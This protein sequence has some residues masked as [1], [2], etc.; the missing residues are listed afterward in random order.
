MSKCKLYLATKHTSNYI[1]EFK[2]RAAA[3]DFYTNHT[4]YLEEKYGKGRE[5]IYVEESKGRDR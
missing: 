4:K 1:G 3:E 2:N 5:P